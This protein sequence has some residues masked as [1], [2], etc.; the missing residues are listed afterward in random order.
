ML[1]GVELPSPPNILPAAG[2]VVA[3]GAVAAG[4]RLKREAAPVAGA[5][6]AGLEVAALALKRDGEGAALVLVL[7]RPPAGFWVD[8]ALP[9]RLDPALL[10]G[11]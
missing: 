2:E 5:E 9:N 6:S 8:E 4:F 1:A 7:N 10:A 11:G 3:G